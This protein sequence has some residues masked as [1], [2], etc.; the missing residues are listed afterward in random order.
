VERHE[1]AG[2]RD[3]VQ[4]SAGDLNGFS[5][6]AEVPLAVAIGAI[7]MVITDQDIAAAL[8]Y[9]AGDSRNGSADVLWRAMDGARPAE[10]V[11]GER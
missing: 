5:A 4:L 2:V 11:P 9:F 1:G 7:F 3:L 10:H 8:A 6:E